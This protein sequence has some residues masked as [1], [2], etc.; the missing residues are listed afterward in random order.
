[1]ERG[2]REVRGVDAQRTKSTS[3]D[4]TMMTK[5]Q[6]PTKNNLKTKR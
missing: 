1:M 3:G 2:D 4:T 6:M 5:E